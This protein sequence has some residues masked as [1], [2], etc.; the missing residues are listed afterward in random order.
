MDPRI[1][2]EQ[3]LESCYQSFK[4]LCQ[5]SQY[6]ER[7]FEVLGWLKN[8]MLSPQE[9]VCAIYI[10]LELCKVSE[11][12]FIGSL[13]DVVDGQAEELMVE[14][15]LKNKDLGSMT[16]QQV[17]K[18]SGTPRQLE[19]LKTGDQPR[20]VVNLEFFVSSEKQGNFLP[21][22]LRAIP[23]FYEM[24]NNE[25]KWLTPSSVPETIWDL[26]SGE[27]TNQNEAI[28]GFL[29]E[30]LHSKLTPEQCSA[31]CSALESDPKLV[32]KSGIGNEEFED[33]VN[34][35]PNIAVEILVRLA[36]SKRMESYLE[37]L[38]SLPMS[39]NVLEV[40]NKLASQVE[41]PKEFLQL[42]ISSCI[43]SCTKIQDNYTQT[44]L[45]RLLCVFVSTL[46]KNKILDPS[47]L[48]NEVQTFCMEFSRI[49]EAST[50][51]KSLRSAN[52][53]NL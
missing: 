22:Y 27:R 17:T 3:T 50:L 47:E 2:R 38:I 36:K 12:T 30:A 53:H 31:I 5:K 39:L 19:H 23:Q 45:V 49:R 28:R 42:F 9:R 37:K 6:F 51:Y 35:N 14:E 41:L 40:V 20:S 52:T 43:G 26:D 29:K 25:I 16:P 11:S 24:K 33:L 15:W 18:F 8:N 48:T 1:L 44:R 32:F 7:G 13:M 46:L 10:L 21:D 4:K 34:N